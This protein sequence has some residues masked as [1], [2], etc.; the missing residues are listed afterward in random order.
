M[1]APL[2]DK[3]GAGGPSGRD[4]QQTYG[5]YGDHTAWEGWMAFAG[6]V[7]A[8][9]GV[10]NII[11]GIAAIGDSKVFVH[12]AKLVVSSLH[13][14]GWIVLFLGIA[15]LFA[16][17]GIFAKNQFARWFGV[18]VAFANA[19]G[20]LMFVG[21]YP[22]WSLTIFGLDLLVLYGLLAHGARGPAMPASE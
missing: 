5:S 12:D 10:M 21:A 11:H 8:L 14:W 1:T 3:W 4:L 20:Q 22:I 17:A 13:T 18:L 7:I 6:T 16:A 19:I 2:A 15:Q 9:A